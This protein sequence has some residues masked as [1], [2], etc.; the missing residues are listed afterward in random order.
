[1]A[2]CKK[3]SACALLAILGS[4]LLFYDFI[5]WEVDLIK[6]LGVNLIAI[7]CKLVLFIAFQQTLL[8]FLKCSLFVN[9]SSSLLFGSWPLTISPGIEMYLWPAQC[10]QLNKC[11]DLNLTLFFGGQLVHLFILAWQWHN[12]TYF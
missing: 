11:W 4:D 2:N 6:L 5:W 1:M 8:I 10:T 9:H 12:H 7:F 3:K